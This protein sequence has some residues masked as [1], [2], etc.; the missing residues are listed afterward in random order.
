LGSDVCHNVGDAWFLI[1]SMGVN[2]SMVSDCIATRLAWV[3]TP[4][5]A[6]FFLYA[7]FFFAFYFEFSFIIIKS[8]SSLTLA[9][10]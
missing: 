7:F 8:F 5:A 4:L 2:R 6:V 1:N 3:Q 10:Q 9:K